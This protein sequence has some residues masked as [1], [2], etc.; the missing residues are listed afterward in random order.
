MKFV[1]FKFD[2]ASDSDS[3]SDS[4]TIISKTFDFDS[5]SFCTSISNFQTHDIE[6]V[7]AKPKF[8]FDIRVEDLTVM[9]FRSCDS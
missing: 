1:N 3:N 4:D 8:D 2:H 6:V 5:S 9:I 7:F